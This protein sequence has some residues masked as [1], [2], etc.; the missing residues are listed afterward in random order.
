MTVA[1]ERLP[2]PYVVDAVVIQSSRFDQR[3][4]GSF[5]LATTVAASDVGRSA[6]A[7][8]RLIWL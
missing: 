5:P 7:L 3:Y 6:R 4:G 8:S 2:Q 1:T